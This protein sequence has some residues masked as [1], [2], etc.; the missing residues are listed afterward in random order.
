MNYT[1]RIKSGVHT[2][3]SVVMSLSA[4]D[5]MRPDTGTDLIT[6]RDPRDE[7]PRLGPGVSHYFQ[8]L[9]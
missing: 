7:W 5:I 9:Q 2:G 3:L 6:P 1:T 4:H 8:I